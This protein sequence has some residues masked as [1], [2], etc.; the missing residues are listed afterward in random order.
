M[1][2]VKSKKGTTD[3]ESAGTRGEKTRLVHSDASSTR[4][5][6]VLLEYAQKLSEEIMARAV[7]QWAEVDRCYCDIPYIECD[8]P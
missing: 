6:P 3:S 1:G 7:Q 4:A 5:D 2:C 8:V